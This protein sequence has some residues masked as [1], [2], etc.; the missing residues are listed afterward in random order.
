MEHPKIVI[1]PPE[2]HAARKRMLEAL[3]ALHDV[4]FFP[5]DESVL[6][7]ERFA[8]IFGG[9]N[10]F[11]QSAAD[12]GTKVLAFTKSHAGE[13]IDAS[14]KVVFGFSEA[15]PPSFRDGVFDDDS[16]NTLVR[17]AIEPAD[18]VLARKGDV[19]VWVRRSLGPGTF[20]FLAVSLPEL[21]PEQYLF[22]YFHHGS[23]VALLPVLQF[24]KEASPWA[25]PPLRACFMFDDPNLHWRSYGHID[26]Q[27]LARQ[28][29]EHRYHASFATVPLD[30]W[31]VNRTAAS[32][33]RRLSNCLFGVQNFRFHNVY[34]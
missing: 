30:G 26:Y 18:E 20:D 19:P 22:D 29:R 6:S 4:E 31:L 27:E 1:Y 3:A 17:L 21:A 10:E 28:G 5:A 7:D 24:L 14:G 8:W 16:L 23:W 13:K 32:L 25:S 33:F 2:E 15:V 34:S 11:V 12:A 9:T